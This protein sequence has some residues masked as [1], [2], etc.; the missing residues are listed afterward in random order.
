[1]YDFAKLKEQS[2]LDPYQEPLEALDPGNPMLFNQNLQF[3]WFKRLRD[4]D[5]VHYCTTGPYAPYWAVTRYED[6][7]A[8]DLAHDVFS[9]EPTISIEDT[10]DDNIMRFPMF[11]AMDRPKHDEQRDVVSP[12]V[13]PQIL[14]EVSPIIRERT[15]DVLEN[16][17][18]G[19]TFD[20]VD[21]VSI[22]LTTRM[23]ATLFDFPYEDRRLLAYWT[24]V[25]STIPGA[26]L[27]ESKEEQVKILTECREYFAQLTNE[28]AKQPPKNDLLSM[29][30]HGE[31]TRNMSPDEFMGTLMLLI[32]GGNDTTRNS[33]S[34]SIL[35]MH[36]NPEQLALLQ[37]DHSL[38]PNMILE[39][40]RWQTPLPSMRR[41]AKVDTTLGGKQI[42]AGDTVVMWYLSA[43]R[44]EQVFQDADRYDIQREN[45]K[46]HLSFGIGI[47]RCVGQHLAK[48]QLQILWEE[49]LKRY[50]R[51]EVM[52]GAERNLSASVRGFT[53]MPVRLHPL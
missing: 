4:E 41:R 16:L 40:I 27:V 29:L 31:A 30:A 38:L 6:V 26:G 13:A 48:L 34:A 23:L 25:I 8:V 12:I 1:M 17:P 24:E 33:M 15:I 53:R 7:R 19:E 39:T 36:E 21:K 52:G 50:K 47:H 49:I 43:N 2:L 11:I 42:K 9:S 14:S 22:E 32:V 20:W 3:S 51:I 37:A 28:R 45:A 44:D 10:G 46:K 18:V 35:A 5:P